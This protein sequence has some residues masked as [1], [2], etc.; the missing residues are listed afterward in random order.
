MTGTP[1]EPARGGAP[2]AEALRA[3]RSGRSRGGSLADPEWLAGNFH[4]LRPAWAVERA[5]GAV[6]APGERRRSW[7]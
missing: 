7:W 4:Y 1:G 2:V 6:L 3:S 5:Q